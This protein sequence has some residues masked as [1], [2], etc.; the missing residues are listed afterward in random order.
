MFVSELESERDL[1][2]LVGDF[3]VVQMNVLQTEGKCSRN[4]WIY[5]W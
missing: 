1:R 5:D 3:P 4:R 2:F